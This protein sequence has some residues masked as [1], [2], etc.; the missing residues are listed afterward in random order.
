[1]MTELP[2]DNGAVNATLICAGPGD[3]VP[4]VGAPGT[5]MM[6]NMMDLVL[7]CPMSEP[8]EQLKAL[9]VRVVVPAVVGVPEITP[10]E[11]FRKSPAGKVPPVM[12]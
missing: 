2:S 9:S 8:P 4:I 3:A 5:V 7:V 6:V 10:V 12:E 11:A 1:M